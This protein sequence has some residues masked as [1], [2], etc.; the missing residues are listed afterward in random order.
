MKKLSFIFLFALAAFGLRAQG[1]E[2]PVTWE[3][4]SQRVAADTVEIHFYAHIDAAWKIY[5]AYLPTTEAALPLTVALN[6]DNTFHSIVEITA[7]H[8]A[9]D[10]IFEAPVRYFKHEFRLLVVAKAAPSVTRFAGTVDYQACNDATMLCVNASYDFDVAVPDAIVPTTVAGSGANATAD[11]HAH[12]DWYTPSAVIVAENA[13]GDSDSSGTARYAI[14]ASLGTATDG[15]NSSLW[16]FFL[17]A[18]LMGFAGVLTP[19]VF[20]MLPM[21]ISF[22]MRGGASQ[23][24]SRLQLLTFAASVT[25]IYT[26]IGIIVTLTKSATFASTLSV[27]WLPNL[28][29]FV[30]FLTFAAS[31]FGAFEMTLPQRWTGKI[32]A[33]AD[34]GGYVGA[35]FVALTLC[36]VSFACTGPFV[37]ALL[38][39]A[40]SG[41]A[42]K[43]I[44]GMFGFGLAFALPFTVLGFFPSVLK[45]LPK[46]GEWM[47]IVKVT[48]GFI[49]VMFGMKFLANADVY[50]GGRYLSRELFLD[51]WR[52]CIVLWGLYFMGISLTQPRR[53][54]SK[55]SI[56]LGIIIWLVGAYVTRHDEILEGILPEKNHAEQPTAASGSPSLTAPVPAFFNLNEAV[57]A[58]EAQNKPLLLYFKGHA[59]ANC[60]RMQGTVFADARVLQA[61]RERYVVAALYTD[62][63]TELPQGDWYTSAFDGKVKKTMG[64]Q[65]LDYLITRYNINSIPFFAVYGGAT[66]GYTASAEEFLAFIK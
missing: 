42:L 60:K 6:A 20:P 55:L 30:L 36:V 53:S 14:S 45:K 54:V 46:S 25:V 38:V 56:T 7:A 19:C 4:S 18:M 63:K 31:L 39:A 22:F 50:F 17:I 44:I 2:N 24:T 32:D 33:R 16:L 43:P 26:A 49:L 47:N 29:F 61:L 23:R 9:Y 59:C 62:D 52:V 40:A 8:E 1:I 41:A 65:N 37:G 10:S 13:G 11:D 15:D 5:A 12:H 34:K 66:M 48:F 57:A 21:T 51:V 58:A 35:F 3:V 64:Q 28:I 27:H